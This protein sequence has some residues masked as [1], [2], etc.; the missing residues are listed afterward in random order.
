MLS[1]VV[2]GCNKLQVMLTEITKH[3]LPADPEPSL[4]TILRKTNKK[5]ITLFCNGR[6]WMPYFIP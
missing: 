2:P 5:I 1:P 6:F 4:K 3:F